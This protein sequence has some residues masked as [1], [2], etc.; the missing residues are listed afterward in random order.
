LFGV[1]QEPIPS[2]YRDRQRLDMRVWVLGER[3]NKFGSDIKFL[4]D[5]GAQRRR[6]KK[7]LEK[8]SSPEALARRR[9][10]LLVRS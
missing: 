9:E 2:R 4:L 3:G 1:G 8:R 7:L 6:E 5:G 10:R